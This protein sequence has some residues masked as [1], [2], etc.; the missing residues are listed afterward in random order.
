MHVCKT[1]KVKTRLQKN[2]IKEEW[3]TEI[4][5]GE[6][7]SRQGGNTAGN[8]REKERERQREREDGVKEEEGKERSSHRL[9]I[10]IYHSSMQCGVW[11]RP[12]KTRPER[13]YHSFLGG[14]M[15]TEAISVHVY[16]LSTMAIFLSFFF[17]F[18]LLLLIYIR[19]L[20][21]LQSPSSPK[22]MNILMDFLQSVC[23]VWCV[24]TLCVC[25]CVSL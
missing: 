24:C 21:F 22:Y 9:S 25:V 7:N 6:H 19:F 11:P 5:D 18:L 17:F 23:L 3:R 14:L 13:L 4:E 15:R 10:R 1:N 8:E 16:Q 2:K 12:L 20:F